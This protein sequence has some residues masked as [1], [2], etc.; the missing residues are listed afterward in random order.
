MSPATDTTSNKTD[1]RPPTRQGHRSLG[2]R[3]T[4]EVERACCSTHIRHAARQWAFALSVRCPEPFARHDVRG[5]DTRQ[6][7]TRHSDNSG[8]K[9]DQGHQ[10]PPLEACLRFD[11]Q[12]ARSSFTGPRIEYCERRPDAVPVHG[13]DGGP[14]RNHQPDHNGPSRHPGNPSCHAKRLPPAWCTEMAERF[15]KAPTTDATSYDPAAHLSHGEPRHLD[16]RPAA[17]GQRESQGPPEFVN[18]K[19]FH[20]SLQ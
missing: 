11:G 16:T 3:I 2:A 10:D 6:P 1:I 9:G 15:S 20:P 19:V 12:Q 17:F 5:V 7:L 13:G 8:E 14:H 18:L 4:E